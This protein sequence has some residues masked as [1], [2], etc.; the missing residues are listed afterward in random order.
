M[1]AINFRPGGFLTINSRATTVGNSIAYCVKM[2]K[3][4]ISEQVYN[5]VLAYTME[6][7]HFPECMGIAPFQGSIVESWIKFPFLI[8]K[9]QNETV[10]KVAGC[11]IP[12][13]IHNLANF[14]GQLQDEMPEIEVKE[15]V[16]NFSVLGI[17][18]TNLRV[19]A[20]M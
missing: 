12:K 11:T 20:V 8:Q 18:L 6:G 17:Q 16:N 15:V 14:F 13:K 7:E 5:M 1:S 19:E 10:L 2:G 3:K 4:D 9:Y